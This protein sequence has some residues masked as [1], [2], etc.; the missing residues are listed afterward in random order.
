MRLANAPVSWGVDH[1]GRPT[2]PPWRHVFTEMAEAGFKYVELGPLGYLPDDTG[3][4]RTEMASRRL[5]IV[6][7]ALLEPLLD[8][9]VR[10]SS[11]AA[12]DRLARMIAETGGR[13][14]VIVDWVTPAR[15]RTAG[16]SATA[17]RLAGAERDYFHDMFSRIGE[18]SLKH[19]VQSV[20]H[21]HGGT[22]LEFEDEIEALLA[23]TD[24]EL[25]QLAIDTG[26]SVFADF[27]PTALYERH[28]KRTTY[29]NFKDVD[30]A[31]L[32]RVRTTDIT[33]LGA[34]DAGIFSPL[35]TGVVDFPAFT[36][37]L[38]LHGFAGPAVIE[39]DRDPTDPGD[40]LGDARVSIAFL[41]SI[42]VR[43]ELQGQAA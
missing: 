8:P 14:M 42:G 37:A 22:Y 33:F 30:A 39:Q 23:A 34:V 35:G 25:V 10:D 27:D 16:R 6:G 19:G 29:V 28:T 4:I 38:S 17:P 31:V 24:P 15:D 9:S 3:L 41:Q 18:I 26:H 36:K 13:H 1:I 43:P 11:L 40:P 32:E 5:Q 20:A 12:A 7:A 21:S 2:L